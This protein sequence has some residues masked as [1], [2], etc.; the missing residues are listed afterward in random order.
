M[1]AKCRHLIAASHRLHI[2]I[3]NRGLSVVIILIWII[4]DWY[5]FLWVFVSWFHFTWR[6]MLM[7][8]RVD[9][10]QF[11]DLILLIRHL[12]LRDIRRLNQVW[13]SM[14]VKFLHRRLWLQNWSAYVTVVVW[15]FDTDCTLVGWSTRWLDQFLVEMTFHVDLVEVD[16]GS[17]LNERL[18][19]PGWV[20][21]LGS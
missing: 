15:C 18:Y 17:E 8:W 11:A 5:V 20:D 4:C 6:F 16:E 7:L 1:N 13:V 10:H 2:N 14:V 21:T 9:N 19:L 12:D 3:I